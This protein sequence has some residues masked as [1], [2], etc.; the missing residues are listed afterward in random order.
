MTET[1]R[2]ETAVTDALDSSMRL[3]TEHKCSVQRVDVGWHIIDVDCLARALQVGCLMWQR[4]A[5]DPL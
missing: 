5:D 4:T 3:G 2:R 1:Y